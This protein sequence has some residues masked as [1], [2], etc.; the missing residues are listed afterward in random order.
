L[1]WVKSLKTKEQHSTD[2]KTKDQST[3]EQGDK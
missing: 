3:I 2:L 1:A